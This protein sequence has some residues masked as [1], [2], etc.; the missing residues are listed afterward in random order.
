MHD[1]RHEADRFMKMSA[2]RKA[3][4]LS[5]KQEETL[6]L[7][8][9][10]WQAEF[11]QL[12]NAIS[13]H[14]VKAAVEH[15]HFYTHHDVGVPLTPSMFLNHHK[16]GMA[17]YYAFLWHKKNAKQ[18]AGY[19]HW[20]KNTR[21]AQEILEKFWSERLPLEKALLKKDPVKIHNWEEWFPQNHAM[22]KSKISALNKA[23]E[24]KSL[25]RVGTELVAI[26]GTLS[27]VLYSEQ[28]Q[29]IFVQFTGPARLVNKSLEV[30]P[31]QSA[32]VHAGGYSSPVGKIAS[33]MAD[34]Q[35]T[36]LAGL[37]E[38]QSIEL[39]YESGVTVRGV[40]KKTTMDEMNRPSI[41][42]FTNAEAQLS[43][44]KLYKPEWGSFDL[45]LGERLES[46]EFLGA[47][48]N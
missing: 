21:A 20:I 2:Y 35:I 33:I 27:K 41:L 42:T 24:T 48:L 12:K 7:L 9:Q 39:R 11:L 38:N 16:D 15:Y 10:K 29:P 45:V 18:D 25:V 22:K 44:M 40:L 31:G 26:E 30:I 23:I 1:V 34:G 46:I 43:D 6:A 19:T 32:Q 47:S 37:K 3:Q 17:V 5:P 28:G 4:N 36:T 14:E 8:Q 13:D